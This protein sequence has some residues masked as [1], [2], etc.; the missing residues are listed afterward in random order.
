[1]LHS[2]N[3]LKIGL[4]IEEDCCLILPD[5]EAYNKFVWLLDFLQIDHTLEVYLKKE[6]HENSQTDNDEPLHI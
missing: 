3:L 4:D 2:N 5:I 1:M 6:S